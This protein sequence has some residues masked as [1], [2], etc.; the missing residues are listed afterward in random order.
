M[1]KSWKKLIKTTD[2]D[3]TDKSEN[4]L[5]NIQLTLDE[6]AAQN[7]ELDDLLKE[8][9]SLENEMSHLLQS[10]NPVAEDPRFSGSIESLKNKREKEKTRAVQ[11]KKLEERLLKKNKELEKWEQ[12]LKR[13]KEKLSLQKKTLLKKET[14][15]D[16][17]TSLTAL[18]STN[19]SSEKRWFDTDTI[20]KKKDEIERT[21]KVLTE[22]IKKAEKVP[23]QIR[24]LKTKLDAFGQKDLAKFQQKLDQVK[25][26]AEIPM[27]IRRIKDN[28]D[29]KRETKK[30]KLREKVSLK[31]LSEKLEETKRFGSAI[32]SAKSD[33]TDSLKSLESKVPE[34]K[35]L[36]DKLDK[37]LS[38][39]DRQMN[40]S[41]NASAKKAEQ[42]ETEE[43]EIQRREKRKEELLS[44][45]KTER[46]EEERSSR[47]KE[48][49]NEKYT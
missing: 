32:K 41:E 34:I 17:S 46:K 4:S 33:I 13:L 44:R 35:E 5:S 8:R 43:K 23:D 31:K 10:T 19:K 22:Q 47:K 45:R 11:K 3:P 21:K 20:R 37:E 38:L 1:T 25:K 49:K 40:L 28:W 12:N 7:E 36:T 14:Q 16:S 18:K 9:Q 29:E 42:K 6:I 30:E 27:R 2:L 26:T 48:R 24:E 39:D 15:Q